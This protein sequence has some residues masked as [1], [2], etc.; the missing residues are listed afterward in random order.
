MGRESGPAARAQLTQGLVTGV[1]RVNG[2]LAFRVRTAGVNNQAALAANQN[3]VV[4]AMQNARQFFVGPGTQ[5][6]AAQG[7]NLAP[8]SFAALRSGQRVIIQSQ[9]AQAIRVRIFPRN[10]YAGLARRVAT[11]QGPMTLPSNYHIH[12]ISRAGATHVKVAKR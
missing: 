6:E 9:G 5:F 12:N 3:G 4:P 10:Q 8:A 7:M 1:H 2:Q 11:V